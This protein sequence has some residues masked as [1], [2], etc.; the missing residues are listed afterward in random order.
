MNMR[1][2][3]FYQKQEHSIDSGVETVEIGENRQKLDVLIFDAP[4][5]SDPEMSDQ[6]LD[7]SG[8][9]KEI[10][11]GALSVAT[12]LERHGF[13][14]GVVPMD[15]FISQEF[16]NG[17]DQINQIR[18][19]NF[20]PS[21]QE[22]TQKLQDEVANE[23]FFITKMQETVRRLIEEKD[24]KVIA[25][26]YMFSPTERSI[27][28]MARYVKENFPEKTV[29]VGGNAASFDE[30]T[31]NQLLSPDEVGLDAIVN[32][33]G[34]WTMLDLVQELDKNKA[35]EKA[36]LSSIKGI[37]FWNNGEIIS[38]GRRERGNP[39]E[40]GPLNYGKVMLPEGVDIGD[41]NHYVLFAR[42]CLGRCAFC[43]SHEMY[44]RVVTSIGLES[45]GE[46]LRYVAEAV[47]KRKG[48]EK[49]VGILDDDLLLELWF[50][51]EGNITREEDRAV[52]K[53]TVFEVIAPILG[54]VHQQYPDVNF[55]AQAR[56]G[57]L[58]DKKD[59][60]PKEIM[61]K[62][63]NTIL[64]KPEELLKEMKDCGINFVL[65]GIESGSQEILD[66]SLKDTKVEWVEP[67]CNRLKEAGIGVGAFWIIGL[68]GATKEREEQ[69][70]EFLKSLVDR[71][72]ISEL[73]AHVFVPLPGTSA[74]TSKIIGR[75][76]KLD[77]DINKTSKKTYF[78]GQ[79][80]YEHI[81]SEG[82]VVL[83]KDEIQDIFERTKQLTAVLKKRNEDRGKKNVVKL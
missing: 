83:S 22:S 47:D 44:R 10:P 9:S 82:N 79:A 19:N 11:R 41:F 43:T 65:L 18:Q 12:F 57:H 49:N 27:I 73:E 75:D 66:A 31:R 36:D 34:E 78:S 48:K 50:D 25:F 54:E 40:I 46:E 4:F 70:L 14:A 37:S 20:S 13:E 53:K 71:E 15:A 64:E 60:D 23:A 3:N 21:E 72:L 63:A 6:S 56:V 7:D 81:D 52:E 51:A 24:P 30:K 62:R 76:L 55:I 68:P 38:T 5:H 35:G 16:V 32:Y 45:F 29:I 1:E 28:A 59:D 33:E 58:R 67:A 61:N 42:G 77:E 17:Q 80:T 69:S 74:R 2:N 39:V 8:M 26:S